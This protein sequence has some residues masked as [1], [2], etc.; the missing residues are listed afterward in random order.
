MS[1]PT[2]PMKLRHAGGTATTDANDTKIS[3]NRGIGQFIN[4]KNTDDTNNLEISFNGGRNFFVLP[5][6]GV[7]LQLNAL[8]YFFY[9]RSSAGTATWSALIGEG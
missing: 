6:G 3:I 2:R 5:Q 8:F 7:P 9:L 1:T 4:I